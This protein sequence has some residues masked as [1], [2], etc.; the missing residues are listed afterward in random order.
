MTVNTRTAY[1]HPTPYPPTSTKCVF[2]HSSSAETMKRSSI[3]QGLLTRR[4]RTPSPLLHLGLHP[5]P[6]SPPPPPPPTHSSPPP[7]PSTRVAECYLFCHCPQQFRY[8]KTPPPHPTPPETDQCITDIN[9][10][11]NQNADFPSN[12]RAKAAPKEGETVRG[13]SGSPPTSYR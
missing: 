13:F 2:S 5:S 12:A 6:Q 3:E 10:C 11:V 4:H 1:S 8:T 9:K 7:P